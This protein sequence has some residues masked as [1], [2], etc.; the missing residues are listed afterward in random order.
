M[1][2]AGVAPGRPFFQ[3]RWAEIAAYF[4]RFSFEKADICRVLLAAVEDQALVIPCM[5]LRNFRLPSQANI[6]ET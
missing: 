3:P 1:N 2:A 6:Y 5:K 4:G